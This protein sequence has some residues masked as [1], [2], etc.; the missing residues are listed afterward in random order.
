MVG[1]VTDTNQV[2]K[3]VGCFLPGTVEGFELI[4]GE[5]V[6][7]ALDVND[8]EATFLLGFYFGPDFA[9]VDLSATARYLLRHPTFHVRCSTPSS[10]P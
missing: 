5:R 6:T 10:P 7:S 8:E 1:S 9:L 3:A 4:V 2:K